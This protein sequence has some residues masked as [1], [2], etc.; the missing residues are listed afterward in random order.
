MSE[1]EKKRLFVLDTNVLMHDP[2]ALFRFK[3]HDI[4][5]PMVVLEELD[6]GKKG[7]SE[8]ARNVRQTSRFLDEL[9]CGIDSSEISLGLPLNTLQ[10]NGNHADSVTGRLFFQTTP[11]IS[12]LPDSLPGNTP[13]NNILA[14][15]M[16][17]QEA[18]PHKIVILV[19]KDIN[20]RIKAAVLGIRA[21]DYSNDQVL[22]DVNLLY[23]GEEKLPDDFWDH[24][25][26]E[27]EAWQEEGRTFYRVSGPDAREWYPSQCLYLEGDHGIEG[28]VRRREGDDA[29]IE[30]VDD[31]RHQKHTVWGINA[32]NREQNFALNMLLDPELDFVTLLGTAG[33]GKTLLTL[34]AGL[35]QTLDQNLYREIIM[36]RVTVPVGEDIGFLPGTEEE[37]MTPWMGALMDNLEVLTQTEGGEWGRAA[38]EDLLRSRIRIH[39]LNFMRGRTFLNKYIIL[40]EAQNLTPKQMKTLITRAGP[41]TKIVCLG[42]VAQIDTPY[43]TETT[44]GLTFAVDRFKDWPHSG[45]ITLLRG[46]RSRLAD[47]ASE[48]L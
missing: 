48:N 31:F 36:T 18:H 19:S 17:L 14:T 15:A 23:R 39:S 1:E 12:Q 21:E 43:L 7:M 46:E 30:L 44:S 13:D 2:T 4:F 26:K 10:L 47:F 42:N 41:G 40:D 27:V 45:H 33:T 16:G 37:K 9:M 6:K 32:R 22:D 5:L 24:H 29:I 11:V 3:E 35:M 34:A 25:T 8:V 28:I 38:T 20:L